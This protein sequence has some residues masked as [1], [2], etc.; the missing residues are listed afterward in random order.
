MSHPYQEPDKSVALKETYRT[1]RETLDDVMGRDSIMFSADPHKQAEEWQHEKD[2]ELELLNT[3]VNDD[4]TTFPKKD[5]PKDMENAIA[6]DNAL[7]SIGYERVVIKNPEYTTEKEFSPWVIKFGKIVGHSS[8]LVEKAIEFRKNQV[9]HLVIYTRH[10]GDHLEILADRLLHKTYKQKGMCFYRTPESDI[11]E[12]FQSFAGVRKKTMEKS[13]VKGMTGVGKKSILPA[14]IYVAG[15]TLAAIYDSTLLAVT[16]GLFFVGAATIILSR[17]PK[18]MDNLLEKTH[19]TLSGVIETDNPLLE[20]VKPTPEHKKIMA[21]K[22]RVE[23]EEEEPA[24]KKKRRVRKRRA[25]R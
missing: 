6:L 5:L 4:S 25:K 7:T 14:S 15:S 3:L 21:P 12:W 1:A 23:I 18:Y 2:L 16:S 13:F 19:N 17:L 10:N 22:I 11:E 24:K 8:N 9:E 20:A